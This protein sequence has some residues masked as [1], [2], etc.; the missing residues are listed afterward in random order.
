VSTRVAI[1]SL[2]PRAGIQSARNSFDRN[3][4]R[5]REGQGLPIEMLQAIQSL[6]ATQRDLVD[7]TVDFNTAQFQL[8][9]ALGWPTHE[10]RARSEWWAVQKSNCSWI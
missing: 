1:E 3:F 8:Q 4:S 10:S 5:I 6:D 7:A 2:W 9:R